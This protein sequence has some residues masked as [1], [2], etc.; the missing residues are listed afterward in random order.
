VRLWAGRRARRLDASTPNDAV[1]APQLEPAVPTPDEES[2][3]RADRASAEAL[4]WH[5][6]RTLAVFA[7]IGSGFVAA[8]Y[9][10]WIAPALLAEV[11]LDAGLVVGLHGTLHSIEPRSWLGTTLRRTWR[12]AVVLVVFMAAFGFVAQT[13]IP[14]A[15]SIGDVP[16]AM[17][18]V[19]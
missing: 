19:R 8:A 1:R 11:L 17:S 15:D 13:V 10:V 4:L 14:E 3:Y 7:V 18:T 16:Q 2:L 9:V 6:R 12:S 5:Y